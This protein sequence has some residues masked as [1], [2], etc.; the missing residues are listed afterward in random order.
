[1]ASREAQKEF[2][3]KYGEAAGNAEAI[4][5]ANKARHPRELREA[6]LSPLDIV[7]TTALDLK[8]VEKAVDGVLKSAAVRGRHVIAVVEDEAGR[9]WKKVLEAADVL[10]EAEVKKVADDHGTLVDGPKQ[11]TPKPTV[12][13]SA[14]T[15]KD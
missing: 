14:R 10:S 4:V 15:K 1:M 8:K 9:V 6:S 5:K 7:A 2:E 3:D 12:H 11:A 13:R